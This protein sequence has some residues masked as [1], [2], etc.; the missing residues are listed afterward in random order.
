MRY[1]VAADSAVLSPENQRALRNSQSCAGNASRARGDI[2]VGRN[3]KLRGNRQKRAAPI[4]F[5]SPQIV[6]AAVSQMKQKTEGHQKILETYVEYQPFDKI[7][8][9]LVS[10]VIYSTHSVPTKYAFLAVIADFFIRLIE[11]H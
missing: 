10:H 3:K 5:M 9:I 4:F 2:Q 11:F 6:C 1:G 8:S 7:I